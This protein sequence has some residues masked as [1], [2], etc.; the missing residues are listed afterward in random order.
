LALPLLQVPAEDAKPLYLQYA[1]LEEE[2]GLD[3]HAMAIYD[4]A[5]KAVTDQ[6]KLSIYEIYIA[7]AAEFLGVPKTRAIYEHAIESGLPDK[8]V[9]TMCI[10]YAELERNLGE[11]DR[12]RAIYIH[13]SQM[14]D[15]RSD[16]EFWVKWNDF[17]VQHGNE[18]TFREMLRIKRSVSASYSQVYHYLKMSNLSQAACCF[19]S[20]YICRGQACISFFLMDSGSHLSSGKCSLVS[21]I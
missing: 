21:V 18:D 16:A 2:H 19:L 10:K 17:E 9:K 3:R 6:E 5:T 11:I 7:R 13:A 4:R 8:D 12:A 1:K 15:P 20:Q 14:A